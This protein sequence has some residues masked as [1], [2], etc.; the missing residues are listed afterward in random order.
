MAELWWIINNVIN[1]SSNFINVLKWGIWFIGGSI[2]YI[3]GLIVTNS[4][5]GLEIRKY[6]HI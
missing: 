3:L 4:N 2:L 1:G 5:I 6:I